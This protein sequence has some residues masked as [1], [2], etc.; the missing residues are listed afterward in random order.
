[1]CNP[2]EDLKIVLQQNRR[3]DNIIT[4]LKPLF[5]KDVELDYNYDDENCFEGGNEFR[6]FDTRSIR[7]QS[8][9]IRT[10]DLNPAT[11]HYEVFLMP[12]KRISSQRYAFNND[13][14]GKYLIKYTEGHNSETQADYV[15]IH[16]QLKMSEEEPG[17]AMHVFGALTNWRT[18][19]DS[20][21]HYNDSTKCYEL[22]LL[23]KQGYY[24]YQFAFVP[25]NKSNIDI[26]L[27]EGCHNE[28][29]NDYTIYAYL[30]NTA[31]GYYQLMGMLKTN[32]G[33]L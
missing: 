31:E 17:G 21:M 6:T 16:F 3:W 1:M 13:I 26:T 7:Y 32:S 10:V 5:I 9:H 28:T 12:D 15:K 22:T 4:G 20:R 33:R 14:N 29:E 30:Y 25:D 19:A 27:I 23:L 8:E 18:D 2:F 24:N 11:Q